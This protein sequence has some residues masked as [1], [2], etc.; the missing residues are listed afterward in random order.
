MR[1]LFSVAYLSLV[2]LVV[3]GQGR[4][5]KIDICDVQYVEPGADFQIE[6]KSDIAVTTKVNI[7]YFV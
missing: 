2:V 1:V 6:C 3:N 4:Y 5:G 7:L